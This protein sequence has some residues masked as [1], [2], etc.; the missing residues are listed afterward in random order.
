MFEM[1]VESANDDS[2]LIEEWTQQRNVCATKRQAPEPKIPVRGQ[3]K[4]GISLKEEKAS[5]VEKPARISGYDWEA[6]EKFNVESDDEEEDKTPVV[7]NDKGLAERR[8][9][10]RAERIA[11]LRDE[12][13]TEDLSDDIRVFLAERERQ[14]G[15]E[16]YRTRDYDEAKE[17]YARS[18]AYREDARVYANRAL[19][20]LS[21]GNL[22]EA[23]ADCDAALALDSVYDKARA[24]R[25]V[26]RYK[27][28]KYKAALED[29]A[30][31]Q[32]LDAKIDKLAE[33]AKA[34]LAE[35]DSKAKVRSSPFVRVTIRDED[36]D[37]GESPPSGARRIAIQME[38]E[39]D[40][41]AEEEDEIFPEGVDEADGLRR[42][43]IAK[44]DDDE[45]TIS[46]EAPNLPNIPVA[47][48]RDDDAAFSNKSDKM[49]REMTF[50]S[51]QADKDGKYTTATRVGDD[52]KRKCLS[53]TSRKVD[54]Q[55][56]ISVVH[57]E[58][59]DNEPTAPAPALTV[60]ASRQPHSSDIHDEVGLSMNVQEA[61]KTDLG[62]YPK[63][64]KIEGDHGD[65]NKCR[66]FA[67]S[68]PK[69]SQRIPV[70]DTDDDYDE[71]PALA[72]KADSSRPVPSSKEYDATRL[73]TDVHGIQE[74]DSSQK[75][76]P[77][78]EHGPNVETRKE[79]P[80]DSSMTVTAENVEATTRPSFDTHVQCI[81]GAEAEDSSQLAVAQKTESSYVDEETRRAEAEAVKEQGTQAIKSGDFARAA[82]LYSESLEILETVAAR[83]NRCLALI[84]L[85]RWDEAIRDATAVLSVEPRNPKALFRRG[86]AH[87]GRGDRS[88][89]VEDLTKLVTL[90]PGN[91]LAKEE[92][93][94]TKRM[95]SMRQKLDFEEPTPDLPQPPPPN[96]SLK[97]VEV[98]DNAK[99]LPPPVTKKIEQSNIVSHE[100][101]AAR[102]TAIATKRRAPT[103][104][105]FAASSSFELE[106]VWRDLRNDH[107]RQA[108]YIS[109][110]TPAQ[111]KKVVAPTL[112]IF[113][114]IALR[115]TLI[116]DKLKAARLLVAASQAKSF[117][118]VQALLT[119]DHAEAIRNLATH[120]QCTHE[121]LAAKLRLGYA[122]LLQCHSLS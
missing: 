32:N 83:N 10:V 58:D 30:L 27:R 73:P 75:C 6:W 24:R 2:Q 113:G 26:T 55:Q 67:Q 119:S 63:P 104:L 101:R 47:D 14:K 42:I 97:V 77:K 64:K 11:R 16:A 95:G 117:D 122:K 17:A 91:K 81:S 54:M 29:F 33:M 51:Q 62:N 105:P 72:L 66:V 110:F 80:C 85:E 90:E 25:A 78:Q 79:F 50:G 31:V 98:E 68:S 116:D 112:D 21:V 7:V 36:E 19:V 61:Q 46:H 71:P 88:A 115:I 56:T 23:E 45:D 9:Q 74:S 5:A 106:R 35:E 34:K 69:A 111:L 70:V 86:L 121:N 103:K 118:I 52:D 120:V 37:D 89:A 20:A 93:R 92:L 39:E 28:G 13:D 94:R 48:A 44:I 76:I 15:N 96:Q 53:D 59:D 1:Y 3:H 100:E 109:S 60:D 107:K 84:K 49:R 87:R 8:A 102:A 12:L 57:V 38:E 41:D 18:L 108:A 40:D 114:E 82:I 65:S 43:P 4:V 99:P 22:E